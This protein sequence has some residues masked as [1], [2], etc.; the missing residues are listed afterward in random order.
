MGVDALHVARPRPGLPGV[1]R[2]VDAAL[3]ST[4]TWVALLAVGG[5]AAAVHAG[6]TRLSP[7]RRW[8]PPVMSSLEIAASLG[9]IAAVA[10]VLAAGLRRRVAGAAVGAWWLLVAVALACAGSLPSAPDVALTALAGRPLGG[11]LAALPAGGEALAVLIVALTAPTLRRRRPTSRWLSTA[12]ALL[13]FG[14]AVRALGVFAGLDP[15]GWLLG[16]PIGQLHLV[17]LGVMAARRVAAATDSSRPPAIA[18]RAADAVLLAVGV[19]TAVVGPAAVM[20]FIRQVPE[21]VA[22]ADGSL[23]IAGSAMMP[24]VWGTIV[25]AAAGAMACAVFAIGLAAIEGGGIGHILE[26]A[27]RRRAIG[28]AT[29]GALLLRVFTLFAV[30]PRK[31]DLGD[32]LFYHTTANLLARGGGFW[33]PNRWIAF[34]ATRPSAF[35]GPLYPVVLSVSSRLGG[36]GYLDH[37]MTSIVIGSATVAS[38]GVLASIIWARLR[39]E[40]RGT[41]TA[42]VVGLLAAILAAVN[43]S[44]WLVDGLLF[45]EGL[46]ALLVTV[47]MIACYRWTAAPRLRNAALLGALV[48]LAALAR[49]EGLLLA[50]LLIAPLFLLCRRLPLR[51][52]VGHVVT[53]AVACIA[54]LAPWTARNIAT[55][56]EFVPLS[57]NGNEVMVY[58]N[59]A[60]AYSG[61]FAG[62]WDFQCQESL[63]RNG[64]GPDED[65][66]DES[67]VALFWRD[68]GFDYAR[69]HADELPRVMA[70]RVLRQWDLARAW[71]NTE[72]GASEGRDPTAS[73]LALAQ[74]YAMA[75]LGVFGL[76]AMRRSRITL[77]PLTAQIASVTITAALTYGTIR[78]RAPA[79]PALCVLGA[80]GGV[81]V[82]RWLMAWY[83]RPSLSPDAVDS[84]ALVLGGSPAVAGRRPGRPWPWRTWAALGVPAVLVAAAVP[85]LLRSTGGNMEEGF[86]LVFPERMLLGDLPNRDF[87]HLYG[88]ASLHALMAWYQAFGVHITAERLFGLLQ[89]VALLGALFA[90][91]RPWGRA[92]ATGTAALGVF[93]VLAPVGLTAMAWNGGIALA[94]WSLVAVLRAEHV[95]RP[96]RLLAASGLLAGLALSFRPDLVVALL[97][98]HWWAWRRHRQPLALLGGVAAGALPTLVHV[99]QVGLSAALQGMFVDPVFRLRPGRELPSPPSWD[100]LDGSLQAVAELIPPWWAVPHLPAPMSL[101]AWFFV[102]LAAPVALLIV[103]LQTRRRARLA[104]SPAMSRRSVVLMGASLLSI[105]IVPQ[106]LQRP[107]SAHLGWVTCISIPMLIPAVIEYIG[108]RNPLRG[109]R[110]RAAA[111]T[112]ALMALTLVV[113]P[114]FT[115]RTWLLHVRVGIGQV[116]APFPVER[117]GRAF[118]LGDYA[119]SLDAQMAVD[120]LS[121]MAVPGQSLIVGPSD[122]RRTWYSDVFFYHLLP[123]LEPG[124]YYIEMDPGLANADDS[125]LADEMAQADWVLLTGFWDGWVEPNTSVDVGNPA[126]MEVLAERFC[127]VREYPEG[128]VELYRRCR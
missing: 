112:A 80:I 51:T 118:Y 64:L 106:A 93:Y 120:D 34:G 117:D 36:T 54:V 39:G 123:E 83:R 28:T 18:P 62:W 125:M 95:D 41:V 38:V 96:R 63:R 105:G 40:Q 127:L 99:A 16:S 2:R 7:S 94:A 23:V 109:V 10:L 88:P 55:F 53:A 20:L 33:E 113:A 89:H 8:A 85:G 56:D 92:A 111:A 86:M 49:G 128:L 65:A 30:A 42:G 9:V 126:P 17:A 84:S 71:Q 26:L 19:G 11:D 101:F 104:S 97:A 13:I 68:V 14:L 24:V 35:H 59:C 81:V 91:A 98:V 25:A 73:R 3:W 114:L 119:A 45:P 21:R 61:K 6:A 121:T 4:R 76:L 27:A 31:T 5:L 52:R 22:S 79:E 50:P 82:F 122:L 47:V 103:A 43:P 58:S 29:A 1:L 44:L 74:Y 110:Q 12:T 66:L 57:T 115:Y 108:L 48:A 75:G 90:L 124:T 77:L 102:A 87:L 116:Q 107:D 32:P 15:H 72:L 100:R 69:E 60:T 46:M 78:F 67:E 37:K 70:L